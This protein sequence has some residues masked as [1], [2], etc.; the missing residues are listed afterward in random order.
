MYKRELWIGLTG[1][2]CGAAF[3]NLFET[4]QEAKEYIEENNDGLAD[5]CIKKITICSNSEV[6]VVED[7]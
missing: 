5:V 1:D 7:L 4:E 3:I 6:Q 2:G